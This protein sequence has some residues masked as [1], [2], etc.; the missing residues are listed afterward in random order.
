MSVYPLCA[1]VTPVRERLSIFII[2]HLHSFAANATQPCVRGVPQLYSIKRAWLHYSSPTATLPQPRDGT[3]EV[4]NKSFSLT[5]TLASAFASKGPSLP[6][7]TPSIIPI[8]AL[9]ME[10]L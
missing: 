3:S 2:S 9:C 6:I 5:A 7:A 4:R 8:A 10:Y 1:S